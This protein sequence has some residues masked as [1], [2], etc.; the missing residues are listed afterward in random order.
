M[1]LLTLLVGLLALTVWGLVGRAQDSGGQADS[2]LFRLKSVKTGKVYGPF[3]FTD[4]DHIKIGDEE[5]VLT[6]VAVRGGT[7]TFPDGK[8]RVFTSIFGMDTLGKGEIL[9]RNTDGDI[10]L[11]NR[12]D[13]KLGARSVRIPLETIAS[14]SISGEPG[15]EDVEVVSVGGKKEVFKAVSS[16]I[17]IKWAD[18]AAYSVYLSNDVVGLKIQ[19]DAKK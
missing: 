17:E 4:V 19:F 7:A 9:V 15:S 8:Q 1:R 10:V 6:V 2:K 3:R 14:L 11:N 12:R 13:V 18:S 16:V 5:L